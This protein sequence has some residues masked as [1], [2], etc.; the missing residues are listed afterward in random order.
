MSKAKFQLERI[1]LFSDAVFAIIITLMVIE[2]KPP[3]L[4]EAENFKQELFAFGHVLPMIIGTIMS[5][6]LIGNFWVGHHKIMNYASN[7]NGKMLWLN[8]VF[9]LSLAFIP[10]ATALIAEN[11]S[12][13]KHLPLI[14][15]NLIYIVATLLSN[16]L[17][18]YILNPKNNLCDQPADAKTKKAI[19]MHSYFSIIVF[20]IVMFISFFNTALAPIF[21]SLF[22][23]YNVVS[24][25]F[26]K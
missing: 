14:F 20:L 8:L 4:N 18:N 13:N 12:S 1:L 7:Y 5:F 17:Y 25:R 15:Y 2:V 21:Y 19:N 9:L 26:I 11:L 6:L 23:F 3:H 22:G 24:K 10:F 16:Y